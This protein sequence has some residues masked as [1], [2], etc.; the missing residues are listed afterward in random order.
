MKIQQIQ[1]I[2]KEQQERRLQQ[3][4]YIWG[5]EQTLQERVKYQSHNLVVPKRFPHSSSPAGR[6]ETEQGED[7][8]LEL[9]NTQ[10]RRSAL[11]AMNIQYIVLW[12]LVG[13]ES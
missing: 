2:L 1:L 11:G 10:H 7:G 8:A 12:R 3:T 6:K 5:K 4:P 13:L 9:L